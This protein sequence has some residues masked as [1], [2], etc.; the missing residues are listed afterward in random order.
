MILQTPRLYLRRMTDD[1]FPALCLMLKDEEVMYAYEHAFPTRRPDSG[2][3]V[4]WSA[5][6]S[7]ASGCGP[8]F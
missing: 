5:T 6:L 2:F 7:T 3:T 1:D 4:R 8:S